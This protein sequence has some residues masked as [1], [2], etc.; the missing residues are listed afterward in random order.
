MMT[1][2]SALVI[3]AFF[4]AFE[5]VYADRRKDWSSYIMWFFVILGS[6]YFSKA[7]CHEE[8]YHSYCRA[9]KFVPQ[10]T[11]DY[12]INDDNSLSEA[13][14]KLIRSSDKQAA[15]WS[16]ELHRNKGKEFYK[17]GEDSCW[18]MPSL[19]QREKAKMAFTTAMA[20]LPAGTLGVRLVAS[21]LTLLGQYGICCIDEFFDIE[22]NLKMASYHFR[23]ADA[24][25]DHMQS[26]GW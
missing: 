1:I 13:C 14:L 22:Y 16:F 4:A 3:V 6:M 10:G 25:H 5:S 2:F 15:I 19:K 23:L 21:T 17:K 7:Y 9:A 12:Y 24:F 18:Y 11:P 26:K 8:H 20:L